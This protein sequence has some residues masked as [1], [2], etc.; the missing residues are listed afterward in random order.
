MNTKKLFVTFLI[1]FVL[2]LAT[3]NPALAEAPEMVIISVDDTFI[4]DFDCAF[5]LVEHVQGAYRDM[6]FFDQN[7]NLIREYLSPQFQGTLTVAWINPATGRSLESHEASS[8]TVYY[9]PDGSFEK[10][11]N[12][13]LTFIVIVPGARQPL[14]ADVGRIVVQRGEGITFDAGVHQELYGDTGTFCNYLAGW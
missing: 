2:A 1:T 13:G 7:G 4:N 6:L 3:I 9:N 14:L 8:L 12:Q 5:P 10:L 11:M